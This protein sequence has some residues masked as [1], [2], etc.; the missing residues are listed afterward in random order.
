MTFEPWTTN[1]EWQAKLKLVR[2]GLTW[3]T[4]LES[5]QLSPML[6]VYVD[7]SWPPMPGVL[8]A[9]RV[10]LEHT[11]AVDFLSTRAEY[12]PFANPFVLP[13]VSARRDGASAI[14]SRCTVG[15]R[16]RMMHGHRIEGVGEVDAED[17]LALL[18]AENVHEVGSE[19]LGFS[20]LYVA[21]HVNGD[22]NPSCH[23]NRESL[24][25]RCKGCGRAGNLLELVRIGLPDGPVVS[26]GDGLAA[27]ALRR[28]RP[29]AP[30]RQPDRRP[31]ARLAAGR[32]TYPP[33][34][35]P[36]EAE[37]IGP[38][39]IFALD[40][41]SDHEAAVYMRGRGF[42]PEV[43]EDWGLG[44]DTWTGAWP[45]PCATST[46]CWSASRAARCAT[47]RSSTSCSAT[48]RT[49]RRA[50]ARATASTCTTT[51]RSCSASTARAGTGAS[52]AVCLVEGELDAV[53]CH[54]A[55]VPAV[56]P[57]TTSI[58]TEQLWLMRA[59]STSSCSSTTP[60]RR[61]RTPSGA[62]STRAAGVASGLGGE[63]LPL[64]HAAGL[65]RPRGRPG[66]DGARAGRRL[67]A[68]AKHWLRFAIPSAHLYDHRCGRTSNRPGEA[69]YASCPTPVARSFG[70]TT[71]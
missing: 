21:G 19:E 47:A 49:A 54:A 42:A 48:P 18:D 11:N 53:A 39:G 35:L 15:V 61:A 45:S 46:A 30:R 1:H 8:V 44:Y 23:I 12:D 67:V 41:R 33:R 58:T 3:V 34:R 14:A 65:R 59:T 70:A 63:D 24:L 40:W 51:A 60:T 55:G 22:R 38:Q 2:F 50:T 25:W 6:L 71:S 10:H 57:G 20:C 9:S 68:G 43:L 16:Q 52:A 4:A 69:G 37:T 28:G 29:Q 56:A 5:R 7:L 64:L 31:R 26:R 36:N 13:M 27:R 62:P 17:L 66:V 32:A